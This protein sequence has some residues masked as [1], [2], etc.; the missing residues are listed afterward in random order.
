LVPHLELTDLFVKASQYLRVLNALHDFNVGIVLTAAQLQHLAINCLIDRLVV[1]RQFRLAFNICQFLKMPEEQG[2]SRIL[3][4]WAC[5]KMQQTN[6]SED[7]MVADIRGKLINVRGISWVSIAEKAISMG[8]KGVAEKLIEF[9]TSASEQVR[10]LSKISN[11][12]EAL[13]KAVAS[14]NTNLIYEAV[15]KLR[16]RFALNDF[17]LCIRQEPVAYK[18]YLKY[19]RENIPQTYNDLHEQEDNFIE[20]AHFHVNESYGT[21]RN[22]ERVVSLHKAL[23]QYHKARNEFG[24]KTT[25]E[26]L[27]LV[28]QQHE[29]EEQS[30]DN[31]SDMSLHDT[32]YKL[33]ATN[34]AKKAEQLRKHFKVSEKR[35]WWV[36]VAALSDQRNFTELERLSKSKKSPVGYMSFVDACVRNNASD[37]AMKYV[38]KVQRDKQVAALCKIGNMRAAGDLAM[39]LNDIQQI[40]M[41]ANKCTGGAHRDVREKL[42]AFVQQK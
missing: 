18:L 30:E 28:K 8:K 11:H 27:Y 35:W 1:R 15:T 3:S 26:Q 6:V 33:I 13:Q 25:E 39:Q 40:Q 34:Q 20:L 12:K 23:D 29:L 21:F 4:H 2:S 9:E 37:E 36:K 17:L 32:L 41:V 42:V 31:Y 22:E 10:L 16:E 24:V 5:Y 19:C 38:S 7:K 14:G